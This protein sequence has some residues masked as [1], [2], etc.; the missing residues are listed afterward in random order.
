MKRFLLL[1]LTCVCA[2][3]GAWAEDSGYFGKNKT[4]TWETSGTTLSINVDER[5]D[6]ALWGT[7]GDGTP[8]LTGLTKVVFT[9]TIYSKADDDLDNG[10]GSDGEALKKFKDLIVDLSGATMPTTT[11]WGQTG[12]VIGTSS[13]YPKNIIVPSA[14]ASNPSSFPTLQ[15]Y[16]ALASSYVNLY[17]INGSNLKAALGDFSNANIAGVKGSCTTLEVYNFSNG[18]L[19][20]CGFT[21]IDFTNTTLTGSTTVPTGATVYVNT[22]AEKSYITGEN[23]NVQV[24]FNGTA[25]V[26]AGDNL[27]TNIT[28]TLDGYE[29]NNNLSNI[30]TLNITGQLTEDDVTWL[31]TN[32]NSLTGLTT[33][34]LTGA[35]FGA[36][37]TKA[38]VA[39][40]V[41]STTTV[42]YPAQYTI[43]D[44]C[45]VTIDMGKAVGDGLATILTQAKTALGSTS[46]CTLIVNGPVSKDDLIAM[47]GTNMTEATRIDLS[48]ATL[49]TDASVDNIQVPTTLLSLVLPPNNTVSSTL[50]NELDN[51]ASNF[52]YVYSNSSD[53][54]ATVPT[55]VWIAKTG[56]MAHVFANESSLTSA[57]YLKVAAK[58][59]VTLEAASVD[60]SQTGMANLQ[61]LDVSESGLTTAAAPYYKAPHWNPYRIILPNGWSSNDMATFAANS[62]VGAIAAV[63]SYHGT[64]LK[65]MEIVDAS[66]SQAALADPRIVKSG[67]TEVDVVSGY[68]DGNTYAQFGTNLLA[69]LNNMGKPSFTV[70]TKDA[71]NN[72][73]VTTYTNTVGQSVKT[74]SIETT[75]A[76]PNTLTFDNP[77]ITTLKAENLVQ[78]NAE[79]NVSACSALT[80][81]SVKGSNLKSV[82]ASNNTSITSADFSGTAIATTTNFNG[83]TKLATF[84]TTSESIFNGKVDLTSSALLDFT[85]EAR[86]GGDINFNASS[87]LASIDL[88][89]ATFSNNASVIH[90]DEGST[91]GETIISGLKKTAGIKVPSSFANTADTRIHPYDERYVSVASST[92][93]DY[94]E[95]E[96]NMTFHDKTTGDKYRYWYQ[97]TSDNDGIVTIGTSSERRISSIISNHSALSSAT[98]AKIKVVGP[99][100]SADI[101]SLQSL[102]CIALDLSEATYEGNETGVTIGTL[103]K[104]SFSNTTDLGVHSNVKFI[105]LPDSCTRDYILNEKALAGLKNSVYCVI[106]VN[107]TS[108][109]KDLTSYSFQS[110]SLQPAVVAFQNSSASEWTK[111]L[112]TDENPTTK[113]FSSVSNFKKLKISGLINSYDLSQRAQAL[114]ADGHLVRRGEYRPDTYPDC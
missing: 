15:S 104:A 105:A 71:N 89:G 2:T 110:G 8:S 36:G 108:D 4:S 47:G 113:Y 48:G 27:G 1:L 43:S 9:G 31:K 42:L 80:S 85:S 54:G 53:D 29:A 98:H 33:L 62:N 21:T 70:T 19:G 74:I 95:E 68:Y 59:G 16:G 96:S 63:Y 52:E 72:D 99:L 18:D 32:E 46:I 65:I 44:G 12:I 26:A 87:S 90:V 28:S 67:T 93:A 73:V 11:F 58:S 88:S 109:G 45:T 20:S 7:Y 77:S 5:G 66:Y 6:L 69:A 102:N 92:A 50:A 76:A 14:Y 51:K 56:V 55:Y 83:A 75:S 25:T 101:T 17:S 78:N 30:T 57:V 82:T 111:I 86:F 112:S 60:L 13:E 100:T 97:G 34:D 35:T 61:Y 38:S 114:D 106:A 64:T 107:E 24:R 37:V 3:L 79:L 81:L 39:D 103:L 22:A 94:K 49:A 40:A 23:V 84:T 91:E 10:G 41:P